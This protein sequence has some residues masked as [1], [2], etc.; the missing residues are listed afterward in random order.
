MG[1]MGSPEEQSVGF[2]LSFV[3]DHLPDPAKPVPWEALNMDIRNGFTNLS[4]LWSGSRHELLWATATVVLDN[5]QREPP[6]RLAMSP[7]FY[8]PV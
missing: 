1:R 8:V 6:M 5:F 7:I 2:A 3:M 4:A